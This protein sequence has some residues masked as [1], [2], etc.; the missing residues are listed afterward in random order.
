[1]VGSGGQVG[2]IECCCQRS[3]SELLFIANERSLSDESEVTRANA[4]GTNRLKHESKNVVLLLLRSEPLP[5]KKSERSSCDESILLLLLRSVS[6]LFIANERR[7]VVLIYH[8]L[9]RSFM[10]YVR[11][12][13]LD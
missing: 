6:E 4:R 8:S 1:M 9:L 10:K 5:F 12:K 13:L 3:V 7:E 2:N 11:T